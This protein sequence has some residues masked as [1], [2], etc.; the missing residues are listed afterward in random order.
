MAYKVLIIED[1]EEDFR[2]IYKICTD[3]SCQCFPSTAD[4]SHYNLFFDNILEFLADIYEGN[5][6]TISKKKLDN[7]LGDFIPDFMICDVN[8]LNT[9]EYI[10]ETGFHFRTRYLLEKF[11][12]V[13][14]LFFT[15]S[16]E[17]WVKNY[18]EPIDYYIQKLKENNFEPIINDWGEKLQKFIISFKQK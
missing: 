10:D 7:I 17:S 18:M 4:M 6:P 2:N 16:D 9:Q 11:P 15:V 5:S 1:L 8:L 12:E 3:N 14:A 13:P